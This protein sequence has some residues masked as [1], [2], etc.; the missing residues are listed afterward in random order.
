MATLS[1]RLPAIRM[2]QNTRSR[3][4]GSH[5]TASADSALQR[6][7][8]A[9]DAALIALRRLG[10]ALPDSAMLQRSDEQAEIGCSGWFD[11]TWEL[12][13]GLDISEGLPTDL[14][15]DGWLQL[16][17]AQDPAASKVSVATVAQV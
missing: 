16:Y 8:N 12:A 3:R 1:F 13:Q 6:P 5:R 9:E 10:V 15:L 7:M 14:P 11:S 17:L 4:A 2:E